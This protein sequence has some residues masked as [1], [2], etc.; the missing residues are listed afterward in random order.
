MFG[1]DCKLDGQQVAL[2]SGMREEFEIARKEGL[3]LLPKGVTGSMRR[4][5]GMKSMVLSMNKTEHR[6]S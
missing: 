5:Y 2:S 1:I 6:F 3:F 4:N